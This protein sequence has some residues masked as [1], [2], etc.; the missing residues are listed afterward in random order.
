MHCLLHKAVYMCDD[1]M[2]DYAS[3][4]KCSAA[5]IHPKLTVLQSF[6]HSVK[7]RVSGSPQSKYQP[8]HMGGLV[9]HHGLVSPGCTVRKKALF[10]SRLARQLGL[11]THH[12]ADDCPG[13]LWEGLGVS[14]NRVD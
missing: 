8:S 10:C 9:C 11:V 3:K 14:D 12:K 6:S 1:A 13:I 7:T 2:T 4:G 5:L